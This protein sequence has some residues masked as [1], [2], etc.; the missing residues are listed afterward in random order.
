MVRGE[1]CSA[2]FPLASLTTVRIPVLPRARLRSVTDIVSDRIVA[3]AIEHVV[4]KIAAD[5]IHVQT[6]GLAPTAAQV[7]RR[8]GL[9]FVVTLHG[10]NLD[11]NYLY[12]A[13][14]RPRLKHALAS[15]DRIILV[16]EPL[17]EFF[18]SY[19]GSD[20]NF[21]IVSNGINVPAPKSH[22]RITGDR[23]IR[24]VSVANLHEGKGIDLT[25]HALARLHDEGLSNWGYRIIGDGRERTTLLALV[26]N[27][28]LAEKVTFIGAIR[29]AEIFDYLAREEVFVLPSYREAFGIAYLEAMAAGLL[30]IGVMGQGPSQFIKNGENGILVPPRDVDALVLALRGIL[31][32]NREQWLKIARQGQKTVERTYTWDNHALQLI[33]AYQEVIK[34]AK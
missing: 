25:L 14:Q 19:I 31:T 4:E 1:V 23:P 29:H 26:R 16:G 9:P 8:L 28:G 34:S 22:Q 24:L 3:N 33:D 17:C 6:E 2:S 7:A 32:S 15:A 21:R 12:S 30:V 27:L 13:Y 18:K 10:A 5:V 20:A 11:S